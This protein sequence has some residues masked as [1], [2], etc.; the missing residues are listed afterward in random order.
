MYI[1]IKHIFVELIMRRWFLLHQP[2]TLLLITTAV[3]LVGV[4]L[5]PLQVDI[6]IN[7]LRSKTLDN[8][9]HSFGSRLRFTS[10]NLWLQHRAAHVGASQWLLCDT[11]HKHRHGLDRHHQVLD[12][13]CHSVRVWEPH[14]SWGEL[15]P[16]S[17]RHY[18][19]Y[20]KLSMDGMGLESVFQ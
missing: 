20:R 2:L 14:G 16:V 3:T 5:I 1:Y 17:H 15:S 8:S 19:S 18:R 6:L 4:T 12:H 11:Q 7:H 10:C 9:I 13:Q